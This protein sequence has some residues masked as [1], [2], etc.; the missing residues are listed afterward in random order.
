[1]YQTLKRASLAI[2]CSSSNSRMSSGLWLAYSSESCVSSS[3]C[4]STALMTWYMGVMPVPPAIM[5]M[6]LA[7][8]ELPSSVYLCTITQSRQ[9]PQ[10]MYR[11]KTQRNCPKGR[12]LYP[13][14]RND[15]A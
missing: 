9:A 10:S 3:A 7:V 12:S 1:M 13:L 4:F 2:S 11:E 15:S 14:H 8:W 5:L 6:C